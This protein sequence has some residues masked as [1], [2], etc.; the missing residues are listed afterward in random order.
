MGVAGRSR[1]HVE[2]LLSELES[3]YDSFPVNQTTVSVSAEHY[4]RVVEQ[5]QRGIARVDVHVH[6]DQDDVL[7]VENGDGLTAPGEILTAEDSLEE[8][9]KRAVRQSTGV[10][11]RIETIQ[12]VTIAGVHSEADP[13]AEPVYRLVVLMSAQVVSGAASPDGHWQADPP[14]SEL[15]I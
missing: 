1:D 5:C 3:A 4:D 14:E 2:E 13:D 10:E 6:N 7:L 8:R 12:E 15:V 9:A 11:C